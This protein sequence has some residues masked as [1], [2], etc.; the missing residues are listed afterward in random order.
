MKYITLLLL[1]ALITA[2][3][4]CNQQVKTAKLQSGTWLGELEVAENKKAQLLVSEEE[5]KI[6]LSKK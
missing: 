6:I 5:A 3:S 4:S 2:T 1:T